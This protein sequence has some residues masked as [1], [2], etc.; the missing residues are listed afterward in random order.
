MDAITS[1]PVVVFALNGDIV[2]YSRL[3]ADDRE[4]TTAQLADLQHIVESGI[5]AGSGTLLNFV[6]DNFMAVFDDAKAAVATAIAITTEIEARNRDVPQTRNM[7]FRMGLDTGPVAL[8]EGQYVGDAL[9]IAARIQ[10]IAPPGGISVSG[11]VYRALDEPALRF[12]ATGPHRLKN[13]PED[14]EVYEFADLPSDGSDWVRGRRPLS[15]EAPTVA[16]LPIHTEAVGDAM[17]AVGSLIRHDLIFRLA[18][19]PELRV[20]DAGLEPGQMVGQRT[21][22]Y[23]L[24]SGVHEIGGS[25]RVYATLFDVTTMNVVK[26]HKWT[27]TMETLAGLSEAIADEV[28]R[29][30]EVE[31]IVGEPAG[32]YA[33]LGD[34]EA[35]EQ[36][37]LGWYHLRTGTPEAWSRAVGLFDNVAR[38]HPDEPYGHVLTA[39]ALWAGGSNGWTPDPDVTMAEAREKAQIAIDL[40]DPTGMGQA[41]Q[42][43]V[44]MS[45]GRL[46]EAL[47][48][49]SQL[50]AVRPTCDVT[51]GL[52]G[53]IRRYLGQWEKAVDLL[54]V[55]IRLTGIVKP[56]YPTVQACSLYV[57]GRVEQA[58][59][60][61]ET[62]VEYQPHNLEALLVLAASQIELGLE[63]RARATAETIRQRFPSVDVEA[64]LD[65]SPF[66]SREIIDRWKRDL[67]LAEAIDAEQKGRPGTM[68]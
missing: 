42:A 68:S 10:S 20:V 24:E 9:N 2:G 50:E 60:L 4:A 14:V 39:F 33:D 7:R 55:A 16:I 67:E 21:A 34:P 19:V 57:G 31:L 26:T 49:M 66:Q 27:A 54:D 29:A 11:S 5:E 64:W 56:W 37:Y 61:A 18:Q 12:R 3:L 52:E 13:I 36:V 48:A 35:I 45:E 62:V 59:S 47:A 38:S 40:G 51:Y 8:G 44:Y 32:L 28:A 43:A 46:D 23:M 53:S 65:N 41:V 30:I 15:L 17:R 63:R 22:R 1:E 6:G 58:A 25:V